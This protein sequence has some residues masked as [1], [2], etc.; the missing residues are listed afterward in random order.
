M[1]VPVILILTTNASKDVS[2]SWISFFLLT[3][4]TLVMILGIWDFVKKNRSFDGFKYGIENVITVN[5]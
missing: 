2:I 3:I 5:E 4:G 1:S